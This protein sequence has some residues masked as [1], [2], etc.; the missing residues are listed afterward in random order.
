MDNRE[1][2]ARLNNDAEAAVAAFDDVRIQ[3]KSE[4]EP[5][6]AE[7]QPLGLQYIRQ[8]F[9]HY[10]LRNN[11][12]YKNATEQQKKKM[13][14]I[15]WPS[16][17]AG[18]LVSETMHEHEIT[19]QSGYN[20]ALVSV[21]KN[22]AGVGCIVVKASNVQHFMEML[23]PDTVGTGTATR[24]INS[25]DKVFFKEKGRQDWFFFDRSD[26]K[27]YLRADKTYDVLLE[28]QDKDRSTP[29]I[30]KNMSELYR[31]FCHEL[32][33]SLNQ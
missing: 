5:V 12:S 21:A 31:M 3:L 7:P 23:D 13:E 24:L 19:E 20:P 4:Y 29:G 22:E 26:N 8:H 33:P 15:A 14:E 27:Y 17:I 9:E 30:G 6:D 1:R 2:L 25:I 18:I 16:F 11:P 10:A 28:I 32:Y